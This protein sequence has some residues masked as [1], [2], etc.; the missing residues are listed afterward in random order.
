MSHRKLLLRCMLVLEVWSED[1]YLGNWFHETDSVVCSFDFG[2][3]V[4]EIIPVVFSGSQKCCFLL[5]V[6]LSNTI[7]IKNR[8]KE[9]SVETCVRSHLAWLGVLSTSI[10]PAS[11]LVL[12]FVAGDQIA[13]GRQ[14]CLILTCI[15]CDHLWLGLI[16]ARFL[17]MWLNTSVWHI[18]HK[19][20]ST[21]KI[22]KAL[23]LPNLSENV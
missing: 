18:I 15:S 3:A 5:L 22:N 17:I 1:V 20:S 10:W 6:E 8:L 23:W 12:A 16:K 4:T 21:R 2:Q 9:V 7:T 14:R 11:H 19:N 13:S